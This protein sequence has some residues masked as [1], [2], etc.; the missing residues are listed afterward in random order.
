MV[1]KNAR[2]LVVDDDL[3]VL[4]ALRLLLKP[5][6][7]D[8]VVEKNPENL[9]W[10]LTQNHFDLLLLD[11][12]YI[13]TINTGNEGLFWLKKVK[14]ISPET[15]VIMI[16]AYGD[17]DLAVRSLKEGAT[18]FVVKPWHNEKLVATCREALRNQASGVR[19][20]DEKL[21][22]QNSKL[23]AQSLIMENI[24][25]KIRKIAPTDANVLILGENGTGKELV[26]E[27]FH[28]HSLRHNKPFV[29]VDV[30][31]LTETLF[32]SELF[33]HRKGA[34]TDAREDRKGRFEE[35]QGGTLFLDEISNIS[36]HQQAKLLS[37]LQ[38][39]QVIRLGS[40]QPIPIDIR[41]ICA[42]NIPLKDLADENRFRKDLI[43]RINTVEINLPSLRERIGDIELLAKHFAT[44]YGEK[45]R[46]PFIGV[47]K[48]ALE[49]LSH[50]HFPGNVR[51]LQYAIER[52]VIMSEGD[53]IEAEDIVFSPI[54]NSRSSD[55]ETSDLR[56]S[57]IE[58]NTITKVIDK[59][60]GNITKAAKELGL[61]RTALYRKLSKHD[62]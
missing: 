56:L 16:T 14:S 38:N 24:F 54:E 40:N 23:V 6:V 62:L 12:N 58:K 22:T 39:R 7:K 13:S 29:K 3:D 44:V 50:Y 37:V 48:K 43:Y 42:T 55:D 60:S 51:E 57:S 31:S 19:G 41:L 25:L 26:A 17:I 47:S 35:A 20:Q 5:E 45:Y 10:V 30:G 33:G 32:E 21:I 27:S 2:V 4:T 61:T 11:M 1:L 49:K 15:L 9:R 18:D 46:K 28:Q 34:F 53:F 59:H 52:A 8:V 36:I